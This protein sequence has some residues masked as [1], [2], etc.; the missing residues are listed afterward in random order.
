MEN[1]SKR[2]AELSEIALQVA[3][4]ATRAQVE[5]RRIVRQLADMTLHEPSQPPQFV[6][7]ETG[8]ERASLE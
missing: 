3:A 4:D 5:A 2:Q 8:G 7:R 1:S 6:V